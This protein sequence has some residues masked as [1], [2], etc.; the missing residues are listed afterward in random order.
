[1]WKY[2]HIFLFSK[3]YVNIKNWCTESLII[4]ADARINPLKN[5]NLYI[6]QPTN[7]FRL[8]LPC[9]PSIYHYTVIF[10]FQESTNSV[11]LSDKTTAVHFLCSVFQRDCSD[12]QFLLCFFFFFLP[13]VIFLIFEV[14]AKTFLCLS[15]LRFISATRDS[16]WQNSFFL[17]DWKAIEDDV[18]VHISRLTSPHLINAR[19]V[20]C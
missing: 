1:M 15:H 16:L 7:I 17:H 9:F 2:R 10:P 18:L 19:V 8:F 11:N 3:K 14:T 20:F 6:R 4:A 5:Y 13:A 12:W